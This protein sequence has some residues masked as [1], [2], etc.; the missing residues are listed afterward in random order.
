MKKSL[1]IQSHFKETLTKIDERLKYTIVII[2][3]LFNDFFPSNIKE[4]LILRWIVTLRTL[5]V[6]N[7]A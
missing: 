7:D 4:I 1:I 5:Q 2:L 3:D 6:S